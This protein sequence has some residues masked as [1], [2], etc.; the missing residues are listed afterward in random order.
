MAPKPH[1]C[2]AAI[3]R[4]A[5]PCARLPRI[6]PEIP[7][8]TGDGGGDSDDTR[9]A[10]RMTLEGRTT[11]MPL[12]LALSRCGERVPSVRIRWNRMKQSGCLEHSDTTGQNPVALLERMCYS[13]V[14]CP[15]PGQPRPDS[16]GRPKTEDA[17]RIPPP[18]RSTQRR[19]ISCKES[20][21]IH[22]EQA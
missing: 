20:R 21:G 22:G 9:G 6:T 10:R 14:G 2:G 19:G 11:I 16:S 7:D 13:I 1:F 3:E 8:R 12:T 17:G 5:S 4:R 18:P 15:I